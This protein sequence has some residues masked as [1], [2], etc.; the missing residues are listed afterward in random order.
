[1]YLLSAA[2][3]KIRK[4]FKTIAV[5][6][7]VESIFCLIDNEKMSITNKNTPQPSISLQPR[8]N[9][10]FFHFFWLDGQSEHIFKKISVNINTVQKNTH[11]YIVS[12]IKVF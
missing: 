10:P 5:L 12:P 9:F 2:D 11:I 7:P 8:L 4:F 6:R 3:R 1:M